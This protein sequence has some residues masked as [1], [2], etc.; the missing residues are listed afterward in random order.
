[1]LNFLLAEVIDHS[2]QCL[3]QSEWLFVWLSASRYVG[4]HALLPQRVLDLYNEALFA[5][6]VYFMKFNMHFSVDLTYVCK[7]LQVIVGN[8]C[9]FSIR[10]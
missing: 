7:I 3:H 4:N 1:V 8:F 2:V 6:K 10:L 5:P 9:I